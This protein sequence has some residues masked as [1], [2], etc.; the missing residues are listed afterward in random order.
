VE[1]QTPLV[2]LK[3]RATRTPDHVCLV[4]A[5]GEV[6]YGDLF[7]FVEERASTVRSEV[8]PSSVVAIPV[9][10]DL[11]SVVEILAVSLGGAVP[12]PY[13]DKRPSVDDTT[14]SLDAILV[15]TSGSTGEPSIVRISSSNIAA[16]A[17]ASRTRLG[18]VDADRWLA[19]LPLSHVGGLSVLWRTFEIGGS[20]VLAP[21]DDTLPDLMKRAKPTIASLVPTMVYRLLDSD[22]SLLSDMR[23]V[24]V[25]GASVTTALLEDAARHGV[26]LA[27]TYGMTEATSQIAT[28]A[29]GTDSDEAPWPPRGVVLEGFT[30]SI[31][32]D[33][34]DEV[35]PGS[36]G[37]I[38]VD[39]PA[40]SIG[41]LGQ[42]DRTGPFETNDVGWVDSLGRLS[43]VGRSDDVIVSGG[44]NV[45]L[46]NVVA[47]VSGFDGVVQAVAVG[48]PDDEWGTVVGVMVE[49]SADESALSAAATSE[50]SSHER[51][52]RW[53]VVD[54]IPTL[55]TGKPDRGAVRRAMGGQ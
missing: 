25:G 24:L 48:L 19:C 10:S 43:V 40:V 4:L 54:R 12:L 11:P 53:I 50:L 27:P 49:G 38:L 28:A 34:G 5:D 22:P 17:E 52:K 3:D 31:V 6:S 15:Q 32:S 23:L 55:E 20:L 8:A 37:Q 16:S 51:P 7:R 45:S 21:F 30:V 46:P 47:V 41:Y 35:A 2:W 39:G 36:L 44:E 14:R 13:T 42:P 33:A 1:N 29:I 18:N 26:P 9:L